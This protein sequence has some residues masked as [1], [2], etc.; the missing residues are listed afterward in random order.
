MGEAEGIGEIVTGGLIARAIDPDRPLRDGDGEG[1]GVTCLNCGTALVGGYC[2]RCGQ[3]AQVHRTIMAWLHDFLHGALHFEG[4][5]WRT[6]PMLFFRPGELT[7]RY[8]HGERARFVSP[9]ALFL[10]SVFLMFAVFSIFGTPFTLGEEEVKG[11][12]V[13]GME[14]ARAES[15]DRL[16]QLR[17]RRAEAVAEGRATTDI[18]AQ[19]G[20]VEDEVMILAAGERIAGE[21]GENERWANVTTGLGENIDRKVEEGLVKDPSFFFYKVQANA[22]K[23]SWALIPIS[24]PF[25]ALLFLWRRQF[26]MY[27]HV[28]FVTY[29]L[30]FMTLGLVVLALLAKLGLGAA[31]FWSAVGLIP[32]L[33]MYKQLRGAYRLSR[34]SAFWR[35][36]VLAI[37]AMIAGTLFFVLL[38]VLGALS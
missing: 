5:F 10:F 35:M 22:Y 32:P 4:R 27:D 25:V 2:H 11:D 29:S 34:T 23:F 6:L 28:V 17:A 33:H 20:E 37:F 9:I 16:A 36:C 7:R 13:A 21:G 30:A 1:D 18:D 14:E 24:A 31:W 12:F 26:K 15:D 19:I 3:S 8:I 38:A